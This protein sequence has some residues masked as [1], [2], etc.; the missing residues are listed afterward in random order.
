MTTMPD[1]ALVRVE[2]IVGWQ[3]LEPVEWEITHPAKGH[4]PLS[5]FPFLNKGDRVRAKSAHRIVQGST[6]WREGRVALI[7]LGIEETIDVIH[8]DGEKVSYYIGCGMG[9][10]MQVRID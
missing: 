4:G 1:P 9:D 10:Q 5:R 8:D 2:E 7:W 6:E 3:T